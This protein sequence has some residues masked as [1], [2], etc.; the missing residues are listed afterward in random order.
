MHKNLGDE[1]NERFDFN[2]FKS[3]MKQTNISPRYT[4]LLPVDW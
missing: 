1:R 4:G 2:R 3:D